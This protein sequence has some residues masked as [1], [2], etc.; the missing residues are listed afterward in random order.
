DG[1]GLQEIVHVSPT[2]EISVFQ[3]GSTGKASFQQALPG[4]F[5]T[6]MNVTCGDADNDGEPEIAIA[7]GTRAALLEWQEGRFV[8]TWRSPAR[9]GHRIQSLTIADADGDGLNE[10]L[11]PIQGAGLYIYDKHSGDWNFTRAEIPGQ[12]TPMDARKVQAA[13]SPAIEKGYEDFNYVVAVGDINPLDDDGPE[14]LGGL[15]RNLVLYKAVGNEYRMIQEL[16]VGF[17]VFVTNIAIADLDGDRKPEIMGG[18]SE[19][20]KIFSKDAGDWALRQTLSM[21]GL[22]DPLRAFDI[23][24][25][26]KDEIGLIGSSA[27]NPS[28]GGVTIFTTSG[29]KL[30]RSYNVPF[31]DGHVQYN[32]GRE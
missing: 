13:Q 17:P 28:T 12:G 9:G 6:F 19:F 30:E 3:T 22:R 4:E 11:L 7:M 14:I 32:I 15:W 24:N 25:D 8:E 10:L 2:Y 27:F 5:P 21:G 20:V 23:D 16:E 29:G 26:G 1:D 18:A 31:G